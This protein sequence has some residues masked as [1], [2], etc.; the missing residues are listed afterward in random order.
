MA[1]NYGTNTANL[2]DAPLSL[3]SVFAPYVGDN[4]FKWTGANTIQVISTPDGTLADYNESSTAP[5]TVGLVDGAHI[6]S[7]HRNEIVT[8]WRFA[9]DRGQIV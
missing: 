6:L 5:I 3:K 4:G 8:R 1:Q 2:M 9:H 7:R